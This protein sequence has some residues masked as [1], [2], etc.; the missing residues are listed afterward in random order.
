MSRG[1]HGTFEGEENAAK[2]T[3]YAPSEINVMY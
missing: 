2:L 1:K 3:F